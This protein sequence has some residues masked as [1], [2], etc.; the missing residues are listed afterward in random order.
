MARAISDQTRWSIEE[1]LNKDKQN[2]LAGGTGI[3][4]YTKD[5]LIYNTL[6]VEADKEIKKSVEDMRMKSEWMRDVANRASNEKM[7][8]KAIDAQNDNQMMSSIGKLAKFGYKSAV[9][10]GLF[11]EAGRGITDIIMG[12]STTNQI[13]DKAVTQEISRLA[14]EAYMNSGSLAPSVTESA[15][16][17]GVGESASAISGASD[18]AATTGGTEAAIEGTTAAT[19]ATSAGTS[20]A[21]TGGMSALGYASGWVGVAMGIRNLVSSIFPDTFL[22]GSWED[23]AGQA[24]QNF[25]D[26]LKDQKSFW[27]N[28]LTPLNYYLFGGAETVANTVYSALGPELSQTLDPVGNALS[29]GDLTAPITNVFDW[30]V[31]AFDELYNPDNFSDVLE[32][33]GGLFDDLF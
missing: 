7:Q 13:Y 4:P 15:T 14:D 20:A 22:G 30:H 2:K 31:K 19:E 11:G 18:V 1:I 16:T 17:S 23:D 29:G 5:R 21:T 10:K 27:T 6:A 28:I 3:D 12:K 24:L 33:T 9:D 32:S 8:S 25:G 26:Q